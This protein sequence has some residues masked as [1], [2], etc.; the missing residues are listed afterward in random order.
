MFDVVFEILA[1]GSIPDNATKHLL[2]D[3][4]ISSAKSKQSH[5]VLKCIFEGK[6]YQNLKA[7]YLKP[8]TKH[9]HEIVKAIYSAV[10]PEQTLEMK[11]KLFE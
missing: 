3:V 4:M 11:K 1:G 6:D 8:S 7:D 5:D 9:K 2:L 10:Y